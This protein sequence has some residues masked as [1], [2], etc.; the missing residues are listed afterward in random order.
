MV[1]DA[2]LN[3]NHGVLILVNTCVCRKM[4]NCV[5]GEGQTATREYY[6]IGTS[7]KVESRVI[8]FLLAGFSA[9]IIVCC[10]AQFGVLFLGHL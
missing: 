8:Y 1:G 2:S 10:Y 4:L 9:T 6:F 5:V 7:A 3:I